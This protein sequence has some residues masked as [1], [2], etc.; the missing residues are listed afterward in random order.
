M[1]KIGYSIQG[2]VAKVKGTVANLASVWGTPDC[3]YRI[4]ENFRGFQFLQMVDQVTFRSLF[5]MDAY[6]FPLHACVNVLILR[7]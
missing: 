3:M 2:P 6:A 1:A 7:V 4:A 5:F